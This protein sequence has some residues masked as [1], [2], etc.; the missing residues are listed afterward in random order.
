MIKRATVVLALCGV[1]VVRGALSNA[2]GTPDSD[3]SVLKVGGVV[4]SL[5]WSPTTPA[6]AVLTRPISPTT[7][8]LNRIRIWDSKT[9]QQTSELHKSQEYMTSVLISPDG[10]RIGASVWLSKGQSSPEYL[11]KV[12]EGVATEVRQWNVA[13]QEILPAFLGLAVQDIG[14]KAITELQ[15]AAYSPNGK[16]IAGGAKLVGTGPVHGSHLGGEV[17][18]W[19]VATNKLKWSNRSTHTD[20]VQKVTFSPDGKLLASAGGDKL[21]RL[22]NAET[23]ALIRTLYG[24]GYDGIAELSFSPGGSL[25]VSSGVGREEGGRIRIWNVAT[26]ELTYTLG[27]HSRGIRATFVTDNEILAAS[28]VDDPSGSAKRSWQ[29][30]RFTLGSRQPTQTFATR[31]GTPSSIALSADRG[32][33]AVGTYEGEVALYSTAR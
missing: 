22:W 16:L 14:T 32:T 6:L 9:L 10:S 3:A 17:C 23:G 15:C 31:S 25:L 7:D 13:T 8:I 12:G 29:L 1:L 26:G 5:A 2:E 27:K 28:A 30:Q 4:E 33:I 20:M 21:V 19:D 11:A 18:V 24:A